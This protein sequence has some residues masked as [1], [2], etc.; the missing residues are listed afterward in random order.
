MKLLHL[1]DI[2]L[3]PPPGT[4]AGRDPVANLDR[5]LDHAL[6]AHADAK[7]IFVTGDLSDW[8]DA[9][10]YARLRAR[11][12]DLPL[13]VHLGI[14]NHDDRATFLD[15]FP[16]LASDG[17]V[18]YRVDL[19]GHVAL[20]LDTWEDGTHA[21]GFCAARAAWL[22]ARLGEADRPV[23]IFLHHN[24]VPIGIAP[25]DAIMLRDADRLGRVLDRHPGRVRHIFHG[26]CHLPLSG[27]FHGVPF[28]APRGTNHAGWADFGNTGLLAGAD[29]PEA[30]A[31]ALVEDDSVLVHMIEYGYEV[32]GGTIRR[33]GSPDKAAWDRLTMVR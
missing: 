33:E 32:A 19:P 7:A 12:A 15:H 25:M 26:H 10:D 21:G 16:H 5:A 9:E 13:P 31:V 8:G 24:P 14:G 28:S 17:F 3:T 1:T 11:L 30:Y 27:S 4:I 6:A 18:Q 29:L 23:L 2:H 22:H 20:M